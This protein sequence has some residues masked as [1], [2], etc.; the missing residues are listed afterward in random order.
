MSDF[1]PHTHTPSNAPQTEKQPFLV[2][3]LQKLRQQLNVS[4]ASWN[5]MQLCK[6]GMYLMSE[7]D[8][9]DSKHKAA[10]YYCNC[11]PLLLATHTY[12]QAAQ[13]RLYPV[14]SWA[15]VINQWW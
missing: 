9:S 7:S 14:Y 12:L 4:S 5:F 1:Q 3:K 6:G 8:M 11:F 13:V 10:Q 15:A 2:S